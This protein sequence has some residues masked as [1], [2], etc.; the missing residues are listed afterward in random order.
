MSPFRTSLRSFERRFARWVSPTKWCNFSAELLSWWERPWQ[1]LV[2][3]LPSHRSQRYVSPP[4]T[5]S[6]F[7][8]ELQL[9]D[10]KRSLMEFQCAS[11]SGLWDPLDSFR[12]LQKISNV[13]QKVWIAIEIPLGIPGMCY[14][15]VLVSCLWRT[16]LSQSRVIHSFLVQLCSASWHKC[17]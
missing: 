6:S 2:Y 3:L 17:T 7:N 14:Q 5:N 10:C 13:C 4:L 11:K 1:I 8:Q 16:T 15:N 9:R 12:T